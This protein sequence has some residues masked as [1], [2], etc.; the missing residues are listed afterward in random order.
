MNQ[1]VILSSLVILVFFI[2][3]GCKAFFPDQS[4]AI[5]L[6]LGEYNDIRHFSFEP[7]TILAAVERNEGKL[8]LPMPDYAQDNIFPLG[9]FQWTQQNYLKIALAVNKT[10]GQDTLEDWNLFSMIFEKNC[11]NNPSGFDN[12]EFTYFRVEGD[13]I[14]WREISIYPLAKEA[15]WGGN[16]R[17]SRPFLSRFT[18]IDLGTLKTT[19]DDALQIAELN[20]GQQNR[21]AAKNNCNI[22]MGLSTVSH[23]G[24]W[25][26]DYN[27]PGSNL[28][29]ILINPYSGEYKVI[30][31]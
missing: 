18:G 23:N 29:E 10:A 13:K 3:S 2:A 25:D 22:F 4:D 17:Y 21:T 1:K 12:S 6:G 14:S 30:S 19:A 5:P 9:T 24:E 28:F 16:T 11:S 26:V 31:P 8:F 7:E 27:N 20:G 15:N